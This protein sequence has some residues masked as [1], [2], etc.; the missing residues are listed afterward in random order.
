M[1]L[2]VRTIGIART[3]MK[4]GMAYLTYNITRYVWAREKG[5]GS[6]MPVARVGEHRPENPPSSTHH[7]S[8]VPPR[9]TL[10]NSGRQ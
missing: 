4:I 8:V 10:P 2:F 3:T 6:V 9:S 7:S 5:D 1:G